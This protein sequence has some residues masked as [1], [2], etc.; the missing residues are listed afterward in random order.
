LGYCGDG[1]IQQPNWAGFNEA[2]DGVN[3]GG[4]RC[5]DV[6]N[7][8]AGTLKCHGDCT[9]DY[10]NCTST[11]VAA[12]CGDSSI[13]TP[14]SAGFNEQ[15]DG[16][17]LNSK[18]CSSFSNY[19]SGTLHCNGDCSF[20][21]STCT[22]VTPICG[23]NVKNQ[24]TEECDGSDLSIQSCQSL[25]Y[26]SGTLSCTSA[27]KLN[28]SSC[29]SGPGTYCGD[30]SVQQP[31][32]IGFIEQCDGSS[33]NGK[34][35]SSFSGY[36]GGTLACHGDCTFDY[37]GCTNIATLRCGDSVKNRLT[38]DC[39]GTDLAGHTCKSQGYVGGTLSCTAGCKFDK[40][41]CSS[42][43]TNTCG[44]GVVQ[45][46]NSLGALEDCD[47]Y[48]FNGE[49][50]ISL[51][52]ISG[53]LKCTSSCK[54]DKSSCISVNATISSC[55]DYVVQAPNR[56]SFYE[57]CDSSNLNNM[58]CTDFDTYTGGNLAC[59]G[60]CSRDYRA[61]TG[62]TFVCG[63]GV[64]NLLTEECDGTDLAG[65]SCKTFGYIN[66]SLKCTSACKLD[67]TGCSA[68]PTTY[69]GDATIQSPNGANFNEQCDGTNLNS[70]KCTDFGD[71]TGGTLKCYTTCSYD[72]TKCTG[73]VP[74]CGDNVKN[75]GTEECDAN[76]F[77]GQTC[78]SLG[79]ASGTLK[80]TSGCRLDK[81]GC[82]RGNGTYCGDGS[83]QK[84][85]GA[86]FNEQCDGT[87][88]NGKACTD[89]DYAGGNLICKGDCTFSYDNCTISTQSLCGDGV[90]N[91]QEL[92]DKDD[93]GMIT[94]CASFSSFKSGILSCLP[95]CHFDTSKCV[96]NST[97]LEL[98]SSCYDTQ[99]DGDETD[100]DCGGTCFPCLDGKACA[101]GNDCQSLNCQAGT[102]AGANCQDGVKNGLETDVDCGA[103]CPKCDLGKGCGLDSDCTSTFCNPTTLLCSLPACNDSFL[104][105]DESDVDCGG[106]CSVKCSMGKQCRTPTDCQSGVCEA[107][108]CTQDRNLDT[109]GD[110]MPDFWEDK[111]GLDKNNPA[112]ANEDM[113]GDGYTN[114]QEFK[115]GSDP[116]N[117][118]DPQTPGVVK[119]HTLQIILL[120]IGI[121]FMAGSAG[122][123]IYSR[124]V[125]VPQQQRALAA[126]KKTGVPP[127]LTQRP[128]LRR[129]LSKL[130]Q[131]PSQQLPSSRLGISQGQLKTQEKTGVKPEDKT[132]SGVKSD[133][134]EQ[135]SKPSGEGEESE[136]YID[137]SELGKQTDKSG[138]PGDAKASKKPSGDIFKRLKD[139]IASTRKKKP[140]EETKIP[141]KNL[142]KKEKDIEKKPVEKDKTGDKPGKS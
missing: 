68:A 79:Y 45:Q 64:R 117:A 87:S 130:T 136:E 21:Y 33:L 81:S 141:E 50:C 23:D 133:T 132:A 108:T 65:Q 30:G 37:S 89:F 67:K 105:G 38:E 101:I 9:F 76:D 110:G 7:Y 88:L 59:Y 61:C 4:K 42:V 111:Y 32:V 54:L 35:C 137:I 94:G 127:P 2:C 18:I 12:T 16:T 113:D 34:I 135:V 129:P 46:P 39:D 121:L 124:K 47:G 31:N 112:D 24:L 109:D 26:A 62:G 91:G 17:N 8:N 44:D 128:L 96:T 29:V 122:F 125:L 140:E 123:L 15:C 85:N 102:C 66:G 78:K 73:A 126:Q 142:E 90:K 27:C 6:G 22:G 41:K 99:K 115:M 116:T 52:Y 58:Q 134:K 48:D 107:G 11:R 120:I 97:V 5:S 119:S 77:A 80:C 49:T 72:Y 25:G 70:M 82:V 13:Q 51:G 138:K 98:N 93:W 92:C 103:D 20:D 106:G 19:T 131:P 71:Y 74:S 139:L 114:L 57:Q 83:I 118:N 55:G 95:T 104:N 10:I 56:V 36:S 86:S 100:V 69:C 3:L 28:K 75:Q 53:N 43:Q 84:P 40:S 1:G 63:D 14:N 60:D